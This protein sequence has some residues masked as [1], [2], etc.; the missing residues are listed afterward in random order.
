MSTL[1]VGGAGYIGSHLV[2]QLVDVGE[3]VIV[4]DDLSAGCRFGWPSSVP[5]FVGDCGDQAFLKRLVADHQVSAII[6]LAGSCVAPA[7]ERDPAGYHHRNLA[8]TRNLVEA[9]VTSG[10]RHFVLAST[11]AVYGDPGGRRL[12]EDSP[13]LPT[14][15]GGKAKLASERA[16]REIASA[17]DLRYVI[18]RIF[19]VAG[20]D[21]RGQAVASAH[22]ESLLT[23]AVEAALGRRADI[24]VRRAGYPTPD[25]T[26]IR[27]YIHVGDVV[28]AHIAALHYLRS[29]GANVTLD[30]GCGRGHSTGDVIKSVERIAGRIVPARYA[31]PRRDEPAVLVAEARRIRSVLSWTPRFDDLDTIATHAL[32]GELRRP[33]RQKAGANPFLTLAAKSGIPPTELRKMISAFRPP[34]RPISTASQSPPDPSA[35]VAPSNESSQPKPSKDAKT[36]TIGMATYDDYD[37]VYFTLQSIRMYHP[38]VLTEVEFVVI[39]NNPGGPCGQALKDLENSIEAYRYIPEGGLSGTA[40][41]N[42]VFEQARAEFV[43]CI[44]CHILIAKDALN[45]LIAYFQADPQTKDLLQGPMVHDN[46]RDYSTHFNPEWRAGMYGAWQADPAGADADQPPF[47]IPMQGLGLFA[48]RRSAW[49]GF[50][51]RFRGFGAEEGYIHEKFRRRGGKVLCLP[52]LRWMHRFNR[53]LGTPYPNLWEDRIRNYLIGFR[54][55][56]WDTAPV[57]EHFKSFLGDHVWSMVVERLGRDTVYRASERGTGEHDPI[58]KAASIHLREAAPAPGAGLHTGDQTC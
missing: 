47:E 18:L 24:E 29:S 40:V 26:C 53:P 15:P 33:D 48:C 35:S 50:N 11:A 6:H 27:D 14:S 2:H 41:R 10:V 43:L 23:I 30:C 22:P 8:A 1:I 54:E 32:M 12:S 52:F 37:G 49:P 45:R 56:G 44:D 28:R 3:S 5:L 21:P 16:L 9:A 46:L 38:E 25:G 31:E 42:R 36:L 51:P 34:S 39:D 13:A 55:L 19:N 58:E 17:R 20:V 57:I 7:Y 4:V